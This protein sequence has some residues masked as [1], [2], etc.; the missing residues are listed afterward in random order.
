ML[1]QLSYAGKPFFYLKIKRA[2]YAVALSA[3][4]KF[5]AGFDF[6]LLFATASTARRFPSSVT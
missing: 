6:T 5:V 3:C 4:G 2:T 1:Y